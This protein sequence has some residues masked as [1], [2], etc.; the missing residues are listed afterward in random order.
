MKTL[1]L[2]I[3]NKLLSDEGAGLHVLQA[4]NETHP[5]K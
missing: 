4:L 1:V 3:G 5:E 2:A